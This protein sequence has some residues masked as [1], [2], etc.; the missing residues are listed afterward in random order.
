MPTRDEIEFS[1][2]LAR[3]FRKYRIDGGTSLLNITG[4][5]RAS[6]NKTQ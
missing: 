2:E 4:G 3:I 6:N 1:S 5:W